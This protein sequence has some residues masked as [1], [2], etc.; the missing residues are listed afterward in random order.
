MRFS[1]SEVHPLQVRREQPG[2]L[3]PQKRPPARVPLAWRRTDPASGENTA[4]RAG[5]D[6]VAEPD[7]FALDAPMPPC[8]VLPGQP[9]DE[10]AQIVG[11]RR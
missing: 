9:T 8:R 2:R 1:A 10:I 11:D 5:T 4:D 3:R 7:Q 6:P